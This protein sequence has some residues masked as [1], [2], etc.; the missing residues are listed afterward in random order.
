MSTSNV[1]LEKATELKS[2][3]QDNALAEY[4]K[5]NSQADI[6]RMAGEGF[7]SIPDQTQA[8]IINTLAADL[9]AKLQGHPA[10]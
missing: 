2:A 3:I 4:L 9:E 10:T 6:A 1:W 7:V 8:S 5:N